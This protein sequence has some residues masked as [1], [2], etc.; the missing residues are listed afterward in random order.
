MFQSPS[1]NNFFKDTRV[2]IIIILL[3][4]VS[5]IFAVLSIALNWTI[6]E[7]VNYGFSL[8]FVVEL[9][10]RFFGYKSKKQYFRE[11]ILDWIAVIPWEL[12]FR[13][14]LNLNLSYLRMLRLPRILRLGSLFK[15]SLFEKIAYFLRKSIQKSFLQQVF[16]LFISI[17]FLILSFGTIFVLLQVNFDQGDT[18]WF[19]ILSL[20]GPDGLYTIPKANLTIKT[21]SLVLTILGIIIFNGLLIAIIVSKI[22]KMMEEIKEGYGKIIERNHIIVLGYNNLIPYIIKEMEVYARTEKLFLRVVV[23]TEQKHLELQETNGKKRVD[24]ILSV[25][26]PYKLSDLRHISAELAAGAV[27]FGDEDIPS[28]N[29]PYVHDAYVIK[30]YMSLK[31]IQKAAKKRMMPAVLNLLDVHN[32]EYIRRFKDRRTAILD[33]KF[34]LAKFIALL[35]ISPMYYFVYMELFSYEGNEIHFYRNRGLHGKT[36][37]EVLSSSDQGI[38]VGIKHGDKLLLTPEPG[39]R[40]ERGDTLI[41]LSEDSRSVSFHLK[42]QPAG[43]LNPV[44]KIPTQM[45]RKNQNIAIVGINTRFPDIVDEFEKMNYTMDVFGIVSAKDFKQ[46]YEEVKGFPP[47]SRIRY[48][49]SY[50]KNEAEIREKMKLKEYDT[51][52]VL[53]DEIGQESQEMVCIDSGTMFKLLKILHVTNKHFPES[54]FNLVFEIL[55]PESEDVIDDFSYSSIAYIIGTLLI[56]KLLNMAIMN[57]DILKIFY[58][59]VQRGGTDVILNKASCFMEK[60]TETEF[61]D[62]LI[63]CYK[64]YGIIL[65][66]YID[67]N[68]EIFLNPAKNRRILPEYTIIYLEESGFELEKAPC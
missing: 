58:D 10:F 22:Q 34:Y 19:S 20:L 52:L 21:I 57:V 37:E 36:F 68:N 67:G 14:F 50:L 39:T 55:D 25:G 24:V 29:L 46:W 33:H 51:V 63:N 42:P 23:L 16:I 43:T 65:I 32:G 31:A 45:L 7:T 4:T 26:N 40:I 15:T 41:V 28:V 44:S 48:K 35:C 30:A 9:T 49:Q 64:Y 62:L 18:F 53:A 27:I 17:L 1:I 66:G 61:G 54:K 13:G 11:F 3:I 47:S 59:L 38:P 5:I 56:A 60:P 12:I 8:F 6:L 2:E